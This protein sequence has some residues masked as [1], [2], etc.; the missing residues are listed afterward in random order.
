MISAESIVKIMKGLLSKSRFD[1]CMAV[2]DIAFQAAPI[3]DID[4]VRARFAGRVHDIARE[5]STLEC[6]TFLR[7]RNSS[8]LEELSPELHS[9]MILHG[10]VGSIILRELFSLEDEE[11]LNAVYQHCGSFLK[12]P[13]FSRLIFVCDQCAPEKAYFDM[14][15]LRRFLLSGNLDQAELLLRGYSIQY[16]EERNLAY[17]KDIYLQRME[18]LRSV[19]GPLL[20]DFFSRD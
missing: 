14:R 19:I 8:V 4:P 10:P 13:T 17:P 6:T 5:K 18:E 9:A 20:N 1:H 11:I 15:K 3:Y 16:F 12:M 2:G 7:A